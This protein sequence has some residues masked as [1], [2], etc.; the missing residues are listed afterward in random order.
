MKI[1]LYLGLLFISLFA[2][3]ANLPTELNSWKSLSYVGSA[4]SADE[5]PNAVLTLN[6][7]SY[8]G[9]INTP[10]I[11]Y[12]VRPTKEGGTVSYGGL[13]QLDIKESGIYRVVLGNASWIDVIKEGKT[14]QSIAHNGGPDNSGIR[15]MVDYP[16][17]TGTYT[18]QLSAGGDSNSAVL[19]TK[20]K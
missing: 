5:L 10:K 6:K 3:E 15:K 11:K 13:F 20:I 12:V 4:K 1:A 19:V 7:A 16:L 9:L 14:A 8:V 2:Q 18:L 17:E